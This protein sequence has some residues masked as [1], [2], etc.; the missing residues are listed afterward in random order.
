MPIGFTDAMRPNGHPGLPS[1]SQIASTQ[2]SAGSS[3]SS[4][5][6][7]QR[8][9]ELQRAAEL[10]SLLNSLEKVDDEGRRAS[11]LDIVCPTG[12]YM[13]YFYI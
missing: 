1:S 8:M 7:R 4:E 11:L 13:L 9:I 12:V 10:K 6:Q 3:S 5:A 2:A